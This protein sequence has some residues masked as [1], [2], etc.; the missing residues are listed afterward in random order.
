MESSTEKILERILDDANKK[1]YT[2]VR[3]AQESAKTI[4]EKRRQSARQSAEKDVYSM[5]KRAENEVDIIKG[6]VAS[7]IKRRAKWVVSYEKERLVTNVLSEVKNRLASLQKS[8]EYPSILEKLIVNAGTVLNGSKLEV[9]LSENDSSLPLK[10]D[11]LAKK[12]ADRTGVKTQL[13]VSK[14]TITDAGVIVKTADGLI[15]VDNTFEAILSR[16]ERELKLKVA[17][18]FFNN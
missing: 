6:K 1:A 5:L 11:I 3:D 12:I 7:D 16:R 2:I 10:L 17:R 9:V 4:I 13:K 18:I 14:R 15:F 8:E